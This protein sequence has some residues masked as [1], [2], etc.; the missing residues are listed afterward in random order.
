VD[1]VENQ[2]VNE[3]DPD[4]D[5]SGLAYLTK[6]SVMS[7]LPLI[8]TLPTNHPGVVAGEKI[9]KG[10]FAKLARLFAFAP[11]SDNGWESEDGSDD[12]DWEPEHEAL[13]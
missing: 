1:A 12:D 5:W 11:P 13:D 7:T 6:V 4:I 10:G 8:D 3:I 9:Y 2:I